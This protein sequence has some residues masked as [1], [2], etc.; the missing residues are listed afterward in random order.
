M[1]KD[2]RGKLSTSMSTV[3][4]KGD[5]QRTSYSALLT[6][7]N[8]HVIVPHRLANANITFWVTACWHR[9]P[10]RNVARLSEPGL[11]DEA[12]GEDRLLQSSCNKLRRCSPD[13]RSG[14]C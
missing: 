10:E 9:P 5:V 2:F 4:R 8:G 7:F 12:A 14:T 3:S 6:G 13:I 11:D 1:Q